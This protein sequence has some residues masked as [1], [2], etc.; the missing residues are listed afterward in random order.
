MLRERISAGER[1]I[2]APSPRR[3][4]L[5]SH[6]HRRRARYIFYP[7]K[8]MPSRHRVYDSF[9]RT[10]NARHS[11]RGFLIGADRKHDDGMFSRVIPPSCQQHHG[12][13]RAAWRQRRCT[14]FPRR[15][16]LIVITDDDARARRASQKNAFS[17]EPILPRPF[18]SFDVRSPPESPSRAF[19]HICLSIRRAVQLA[20]LRQYLP[21]RFVP[22]ILRPEK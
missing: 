1:P 3:L 6:G 15:A 11:R 22:Y 12:R 13:R 20:S 10:K 9:G 5:C 18:I 8:H 17:A 14:R 4:P 19:W 21:P 2:G 7:L 16:F